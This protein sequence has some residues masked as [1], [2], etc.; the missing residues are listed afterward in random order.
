MRYSLIFSILLISLGGCKLQKTGST[1]ADLPDSIA[2]NDVISS[3]IRIDSIWTHCNVNTRIKSLKL[4]NKEYLNGMQIPPE[5]FSVSYEELFSFFDSQNN[6][7]LR[8]IDSNYITQQVDYYAIYNLSDSITAL[9]NKNDDSFYEFYLPIFSHDKSQVYVF[10]ARE[11]GPL[12]G[13]FFESVLMRENE[14]W[15]RK[16]WDIIGGR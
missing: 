7:N 12:C 11:C 8:T 4:Y 5:P 1:K 14:R 16:Y 9:F 15:I 13:T 3:I 2:I 10:Y 6:F